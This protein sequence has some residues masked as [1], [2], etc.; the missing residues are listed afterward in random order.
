MKRQA[1]LNLIEKIAYVEMFVGNIFQAKNFF[2]NAM[3]FEQVGMKKDE[4]SY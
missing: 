4:N 2:I 1:G 3:K